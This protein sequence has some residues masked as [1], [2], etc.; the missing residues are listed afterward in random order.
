[1]E[2][3]MDNTVEDQTFVLFNFLFNPYH[4]IYRRPLNTIYNGP[5]NLTL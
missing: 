2:V 3:K 1:M 4:S 5:E